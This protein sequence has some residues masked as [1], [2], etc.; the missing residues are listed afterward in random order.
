MFVRRLNNEGGGAFSGVWLI[1]GPYE[2]DEGGG[3]RC[4]GLGRAT[5]RHLR[6]RAKNQNSLSLF[7]PSLPCP[8]HSPRLL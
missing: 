2:G 1:M 8:V 7:V 6:R 3:G 5:A 4:H